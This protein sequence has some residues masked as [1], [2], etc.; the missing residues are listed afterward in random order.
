ML[1]VIRKTMDIK[2][3]IKELGGIQPPH[4]AFYVEAIRF[5]TEAAINSIEFLADFTKMSNDTNG[6]YEMTRE[7]E[8]NILDSLQNM[9]THVASLSKYFWPVKDGNFKLHKKRGQ[10]L[11]KHFGIKDQ[12]PLK[13]RNL[14]NQLE[15]FDENLD[16]YLWG[17]PIVGH[18]YTSHVGGAIDGK[19]V[20]QHFFRAFYIDT[21]VFET[22]G[23]R[24]EVQPIVDELC[25]I[26]EHFHKN[27]IIRVKS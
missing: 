14:R 18:V 12:S 24:Y 3:A 21:G 8:I 17:K 5:N 2:K 16:N 20:P 23:V 11:R 13:N 1:C 22:L 10:T 7:L 25:K 15:H 9:L 4:L 26:Y 27:N 19:G 6:D